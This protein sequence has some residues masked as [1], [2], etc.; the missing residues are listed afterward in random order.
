MLFVLTAYD[1]NVCIQAVYVRND[2]I[3]VLDVIGSRKVIDLPHYVID[4]FL[5][6][7]LIGLDCNDSAAFAAYSRRKTSYRMDRFSACIL[8][9]SLAIVSRYFYDVFALVL[10]GNYAAVRANHACYFLFFYHYSYPLMY[11]A[12]AVPATT[13]SF[14]TLSTRSKTFLTL[15]QANIPGMEV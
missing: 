13:A 4:V 7:R 3:A 8:K 11:A 14:D 5:R 12:A 15:P 10:N 1:Y 9:T 6:Y 2:N